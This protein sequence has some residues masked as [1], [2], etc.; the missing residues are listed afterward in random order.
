[1]NLFWVGLNAS[2]TDHEAKEF[3]ASNSKD[4]FL[5]VETHPV[6]EELSKY[7]VKVGNVVI[8]CISLNQ[9][10]VD[11][12]FHNL[13][14]FIFKHGVNEPLISCPRILEAKG[15]DLV[16]V[17]SFI[18]DKGCVGLVGGV[19]FD[20]VVARVGI[21]E[22]ERFEASCGVN[23][24]V[25]SWQGEAVHGASLVKVRVVNTHTPLT[26]RFGDHDDVGDP[27]RVRDLADEFDFLESLD[28]SLDSSILVWVKGTS[29]L[30][31]RGVVLED[32]EFVGDD[33]RGDPRHVGV[34]PSE[35]CLFFLEESN[36]LVAEF[37]AET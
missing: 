22:A 6:F 19:H 4:A 31:D 10:V 33:V 37:R 12:H 21:E 1:M 28:L 9:H 20:L 7:S 15:H 8:F 35:D 24:L 14:N 26:V 29:L 17:Q 13:T 18:G 23:Q 11:I 2:F 16:T 5:R 27:C 3:A 25:D 30:P 32:V 34:G 36:E